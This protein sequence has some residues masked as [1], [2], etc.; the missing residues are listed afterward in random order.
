M[1]VGVGGILPNLTRI[2][3][4]THDS[5]DAIVLGGARKEMGMISF[6]H[7]LN[8]EQSRAIHAF[9]IEQAHDVARK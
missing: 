6:A 3:V 2:P 8:V 5:W 9:V 4:S 1:D 7:V